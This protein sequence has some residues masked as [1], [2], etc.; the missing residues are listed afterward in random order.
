MLARVPANPA[1]LPRG[2]AFSVQA[3][4]AEGAHRGPVNT[5]GE[6]AD[7]EQRLVAELGGLVAQHGLGTPH[8]HTS[9]PQPADQAGQFAVALEGVVA[10]VTARGVGGP[11]DS[12]VS[13]GFIK[14]H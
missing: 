13:S 14:F 11:G 3:G 7:V 4:R 6:Q 2:R 8:L 12:F 9:V 1:G 10:Q 5:T